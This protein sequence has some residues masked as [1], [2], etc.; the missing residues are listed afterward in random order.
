[1]VKEISK[2]KVIESMS[3]TP[4]IH[5]QLLKSTCEIKKQYGSVGENEEGVLIPPYDLSIL[6]TFMDINTWH[7]KCIGIKSACIS[8]LGWHIE[9]SNENEK[10]ELEKWVKDCTDEEDFSSLITKFTT[11]Y[12][13]TGNA[14]L[15]IARDPITNKPSKIYHARAVSMGICSKGKEYIQTKNSKENK[16]RKYN[17]ENEYSQLHEM[18]HFK[19]YSPL[20][21][22]YGVPEWL[23]GLS[24]MIGDKNSMQYNINFFNNNAIPPLAMIVKGGELT[25][26]VEKTLKQFLSENTKG[27]DNAH[28]VVLITLDDPDQEIEFKELTQQM[29]D[30]AFGE[31]RKANRDEIASIHGVP[32]RILGIIAAGSLGGG[33]EVEGQLTIFKEVLIGPRQRKLEYLLNNQIVRK[34]LGIEQAYIKFNELDITVQSSDA[35]N[36]A[37]LSAAYAQLVQAGVVD[38]TYA[39]EKLEIAKSAIPRKENIREQILKIQKS[40]NN[41]ISINK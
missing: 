37:T 30:Q 17:A 35:S 39:A 27:L 4:G 32:P 20:E 6:A 22:W 23:P 13:A 31:F 2:I 41:A 21:D 7:R 38:A 25:P 8:D 10:K 5:I 33:G 29:K 26:D 28:R 15:E 18:L 12:E 34:G 14:W 11:D 9:G 1:M 24:A 19:Q 40:I 3:A 36:F 16:F